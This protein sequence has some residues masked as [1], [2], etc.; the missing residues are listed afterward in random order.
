MAFVFI[1]ILSGHV[2]FYRRICLAWNPYRDSNSLSVIFSLI[3][4]S[5]SYCFKLSSVTGEAVFEK[6]NV[7]IQGGEPLNR[8]VLKMKGGTGLSQSLFYIFPEPPPASICFRFFTL[9]FLVAKNLFY[10]TK[11]PWGGRDN[12]I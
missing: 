3:E 9:A 11:A 2:S 4:S 1:F 10:I 8:Y 5:V 6:L 12:F 7:S